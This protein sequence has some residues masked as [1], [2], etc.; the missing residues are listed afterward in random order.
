MKI[1][2]LLKNRRVLGGCTA[3]ALAAVIGGTALWQDAS[4]PELPMHTD[5]IMEAT[6]TDDE[7]PL[8]TAPKTTTKTSKKTSKKTVKLKKKS[9]KTYKKKLPTTTK[10]STK[11]TQNS[12]STVTTTTT[13]KTAKVEQYKK[14]T[15][16][17]T[18]TTTVTTTVK[19]T[20]VDKV[21]TM[22]AAAKT[23]TASTGSG[24]AQKTEKYTADVTKLAPNMDSRVINAYKKLGFTVEINSSVNYSGLFDAQDASITLKA[25]DDTIYH[26]LGHFL[27]FIAGN[28]DTK[29]DCVNAYNQEKSK[30]TGVSKAYASQSASEYFAESVKNYVENPA[31]LKSTR[32]LTYAVIVS[33]LDKVTDAQINKILA[34]YGPLWS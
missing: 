13:T 22:S 9:T 1:R 14:G 20:T 25:A 8:A 32:P 7:A 10:K 18:V 23:T 21:A 19:T 29:T 11:T 2:E 34:V 5:P 31:S 27:A 6:I 30:M 4:V 12:T 16:K 24:S 15:N 26:E 33:A 3:I 17:K 28:I